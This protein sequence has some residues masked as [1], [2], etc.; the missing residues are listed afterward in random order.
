MLPC[1]IATMML[2]EA[3]NSFVPPVS[4]HL[5]SHMLLQCSRVIYPRLLVR[6]QKS[7]C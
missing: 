2:N 6:K 7:P 5:Y 1:V 4:A 3:L